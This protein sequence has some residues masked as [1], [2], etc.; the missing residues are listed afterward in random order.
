MHVTL[1]SSYLL[2]SRE[3]QLEIQYFLSLKLPFSLYTHQ[4]YN[5]KPESIQ[6]CFHE[7]L[8][9]FQKFPSMTTLLQYH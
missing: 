8:S 2:S 5:Q 6:F 7:T 9:H 3:S 4:D 1:K